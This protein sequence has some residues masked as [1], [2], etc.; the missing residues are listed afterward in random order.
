MGRHHITPLASEHLRDV[1]RHGI[2]RWGT[3][4][5]LAYT[6]AFDKAFRYIADHHDRLP[7]KSRLTGYD[8]LNL[9]VVGSHYVVF[10]VLAPGQVAI[11][12]VL[13]QHMD[14]STRLRELQGRTADEIG[15]I[16]A[17]LLRDQFK[18]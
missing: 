4:Q 12:S 1:A 6:E 11:T 2:R 18:D 16:R 13:H 8:R 5:A 9:H 3:A 14:V 10:M 17:G 15:N 7:D